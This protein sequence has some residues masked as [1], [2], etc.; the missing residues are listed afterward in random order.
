MSY[1]LPSAERVGALLRSI[2][3]AVDEL[4]AGVP[5]LDRQRSRTFSIFDLLERCADDEV[6]YPPTS[7]LS[8]GGS[9]NGGYPNPV[10]TLVTEGEPG[11]PQGLFEAVLAELEGAK[12]R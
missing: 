2:T 12:L 6:G 4:Q 9:G 8:A 7:G 11:S 1:N 5:A 10:M 3:G